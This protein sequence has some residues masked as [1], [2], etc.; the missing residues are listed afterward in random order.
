MPAAARPRAAA[1]ASTEL[2]SLLA[3]AG[4]PLPAYDQCIHASHFFNLLDARGAISVA[5]RARYIGRVRALA[6]MCARVWQGL[7]AV[8]VKS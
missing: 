4:L 5:E 7:P 8:E 2:G 3:T 6:L 1:G